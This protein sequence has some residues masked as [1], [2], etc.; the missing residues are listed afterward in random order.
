MDSSPTLSLAG[1]ESRHMGSSPNLCSGLVQAIR[2]V[3]FTPTINLQEERH[4]SVY[5]K[6]SQAES[7]LC[8]LWLEGPVYGLFLECPPLCSLP[9]SMPCYFQL[10]LL[11][12]SS[13]QHNHLSSVTE[14]W[15][16]LLPITC[17][18]SSLQTPAPAGCS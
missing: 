18:W 6:L 3:S 11:G 2:A 13:L 1:F 12:A 16:G 5:N 10:F 17:S 7:S 15:A 9:F 8:L 4:N 14:P